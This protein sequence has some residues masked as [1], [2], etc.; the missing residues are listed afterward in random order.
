MYHA[1]GRGD[2]THG[3]EEFGSVRVLG[4]ENTIIVSYPR[5]S[6]MPMPMFCFVF[7]LLFSPRSSSRSRTAVAGMFFG[8]SWEFSLCGG[9]KQH[10]YRET[11]FLS[12]DGLSNFLFSF[13]TCTKL[14]CVGRRQCC[15]CCSWFP[16]FFLFS[17]FSPTERLLLKYLRFSKWIVILRK[18]ASCLYTPESI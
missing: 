12:R 15:Q 3:T 10:E 11:L 2:G 16:F 1:A 14:F 7:L 8:F 4:G 9:Q 6:R 13:F 5:P 18:N 17:F